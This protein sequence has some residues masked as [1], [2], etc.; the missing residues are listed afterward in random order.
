MAAPHPDLA[1]ATLSVLF[2]A[3]LIAASFWILQPFLPAI[4]WAATLVVATWPLMIWVQRHTGN[5]RTIAV[6]AMTTMLLLVLIVPFWLAINTIIANTE[7]ITELA[8]AALSL[9]IP[10]PPSWMGEIP[11]VGE[12]I[13]DMW[14]QFTAAG[15][16][17]LTPK[18][19]PYIGT[20]TQ[21]LASTAG[22]I[23]W[24]FVQFLLTTA[25]A[26]GM[27]AAGEQAS[28][29]SLRFGRRLGGERGEMAVRLAAQAIRGVALGVVV[30][31]L[32]QGMVGGIGLAVVGV[33]FAPVLTALMFVMCLIQIGPTLVLIPAVG[34]LYYA[35]ENVSATVLLGFTI[36]AV[37]MDN[38]LRPILIRAGADLPLLLILAGV[39]GGLIAFG[40][41]GIFLGP[42]VLAI[43]YTL[44]NAWMAEGDE[45]IPPATQ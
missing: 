7:A 40:I 26:A 35:G 23:G 41:L 6:L 12:S 36:V 32:A 21:G 39:I 38:V 5:R 9:R 45:P 44:V 15:I 37:T 20:F 34:W 16:M 2:I 22:N 25:I 31:A 8:R 1:R 17:D 33:P 13:V 43:A 3:G 29:A 28:A 10:P 24:M 18:L 27:Y 19:T 42:T 11:L 4:I 14:G 30:T